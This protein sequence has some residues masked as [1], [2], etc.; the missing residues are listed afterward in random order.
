MKRWDGAAHVDLVTA[1]RWDGSAFVPLTVAKR[2]DGSAFVAITLPG[3]GGGDIGATGS[4]NPAT[5]ETVYA[6]EDLAT[7]VV[8]YAVTIT[9]AGGTAPY[10]YAWTYVSGSSGVLCDVP[11]ADTTTFSATIYRGTSRN[12]V[13]RCTVTDAALD[14][15][16]VDITVNLTR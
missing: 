2:W 12:A 7:D 14:T 5:T 1:E 3:G 11:D 8:S 9:A 6:E 4:P 10:T 13:W 16:V 15:A